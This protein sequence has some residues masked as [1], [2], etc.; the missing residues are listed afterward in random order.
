M[1]EYVGDPGFAV[2]LVADSE[3]RNWHHLLL[4]PLDPR[5]PARHSIWTPILEYMQEALYKRDRRR[6]NTETLYIRNAVTSPDE[7]PEGMRLNWHQELRDKIDSLRTSL[8]RQNPKVILTFGA[9]AF[10]FVRRFRSEE[11]TY[12]YSH[13]G[14]A[15][16]GNEFRKRITSYDVSKTNILP[17]LHVSISRGK[18]L[19]SHKYFVGEE[20]K[21]P[22]NYFEYVG[23]KLAELFLQRLALEPIWV[24]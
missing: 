2:W 5:H 14:T 8:L 18:F 6:F 19:E 7:K 21:K 3:P 22:P 23:G 15:Q 1:K 20:G 9:F 17:L 13:W 4:T 10:E 12:P 11:P 24:E 16:L